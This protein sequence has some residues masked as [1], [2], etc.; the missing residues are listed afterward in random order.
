MASHPTAQT[1]V[2]FL[3]TRLDGDDARI[4]SISA[5]VTSPA[6]SELEAFVN[7]LKLGLTQWATQTDEGRNAWSRSSHD[8]NVGDLDH[9]QSMPSL[10]HHLQTVGITQLTVELSPHLIDLNTWHYD[11]ILIDPEMEMPSSPR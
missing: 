9:V 5:R 11:T 4:A 2:N 10:I 8:F 6:L 7:T 1:Q 3:V